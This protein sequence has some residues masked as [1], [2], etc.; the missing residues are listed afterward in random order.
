MKHFLN[1]T[2]F[3]VSVI[4]QENIE[5]VKNSSMTTE[6]CS[7]TS[8]GTPQGRGEYLKSCEWSEEELC[9]HL[10]IHAPHIWLKGDIFKCK[11]CGGCFDKDHE[12]VHMFTVEWQDTSDELYYFSDVWRIYPKLV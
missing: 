8:G 2:T 10:G 11:F 12:D 3:L 7:F 5:E 6:E 4:G 1:F 9:K